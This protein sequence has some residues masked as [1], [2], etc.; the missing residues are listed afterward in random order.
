MRI[1][2]EYLDVGR[3]SFR[4]QYDAL[5]G[6]GDGR[7]KDGGAVFKQN[8]GLLQTAVFNLCDANFANR[9]NGADF[10]LSDDADGPETIRQVRVI[11]LPAGA[12]TYAVDDFGANPFDDQPDS[13]AIQSVLDQACSGC[14]GA[15][16]IRTW[17]LN[18]PGLLD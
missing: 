15:V 5:P 7:F 10:R 9:D 18:L 1:E 12:T 11:G 6:A 14:D 17:Q 2:V 3:D 16:H 4:I 8:S 13:A